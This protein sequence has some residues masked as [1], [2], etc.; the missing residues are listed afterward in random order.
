V[1]LL[2]VTHGYSWLTLSPLGLSITS[3]GR[4]SCS[5]PEVSATRYTSHL[6]CES[7]TQP[8]LA[9]F[10]VPHPPPSLRSLTRFTLPTLFVRPK[11]NSVLLTSCACACDDAITEIN[12]CGCF[13]IFI[14]FTQGTHVTRKRGTVQHRLRC[15]PRDRGGAALDC[16]GF[17]DA[18]LPDGEQQGEVHRHLLVDFQSG[19]CR[20]GCCL[21]GTEL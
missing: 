3:W 20:G 13:F 5:S 6:T 16:P 14:Y 18:R 1:D 12:P 21:V 9:T 7:G 17:A 2:E 15:D 10:H 11:R 8:I 4:V 19:W